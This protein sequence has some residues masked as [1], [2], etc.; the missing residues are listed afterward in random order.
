M[1]RLIDQFEGMPVQ[2]LQTGRAIAE[3]TD[4]IINP[5]GLVIPAFFAAS[6]V[7][8]ELIL[9]TD[10]IREVG[11]Y[12]AIVDDES[13]LMEAK[14]LVRLEEIIK[15]NYQLKGKQV[16]N[17]DNHRLGK[18]LDFIVDDKSFSVQKLH[19]SQSM[20]KSLGS[21]SRVI[22]RSQIIEVNDAQVIVDADSREKT[23]TRKAGLNPQAG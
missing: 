11:A 17:Q 22:D 5:D 10:D 13:K 4:P 3:I 7:D 9:H 23:G 15:L 6:R 2:S 19:I 1:L 16:V 21:M 8:P 20:I 18:V 12:G 14:D